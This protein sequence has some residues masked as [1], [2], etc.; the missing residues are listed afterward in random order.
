MSAL[1][2]TL[3]DVAQLVR[4]PPPFCTCTCLEPRVHVS[5]S[6]TREAPTFPAPMHDDSVRDCKGI[7]ADL[8]EFWSPSFWLSHIL[9]LLA[10][11]RRQPAGARPSEVL[12]ALGARAALISIPFK[13]P[14]TRDKK[15]RRVSHLVFFLAEIWL[16]HAAID[17]HG[18]L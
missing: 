17:H 5:S 14:Q 10:W 8:T 13:P 11:L 2:I 12:T 3:A 6:L 16:L 15:L 9:T 18:G 1:Q 4:S 7:H